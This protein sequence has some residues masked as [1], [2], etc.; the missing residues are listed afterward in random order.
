MIRTI[1]IL[2]TFILLVGILPAQEV[3]TGLQVN[4][5]VKGAIAAQGKPSLKNDV[6]LT[7][8]FF[9]D[10]SDGEVFPASARWTDHDVFINTD[11]PVFPITAG[12]ATFDAI[13]ANGELHS[14]ASDNRFRSDYLTSHPVRLDSVFLPEPKALDASDS[15]YLS[16]Y[17]Q[18]EGLG[19]APAEGDSL[20]LEF[21]HDH[22]VDSL[23]QWVKVWSTPGM[24]LNA[25]F[26]LH[27]SYFKNVMIPIVD[28]AYLK[29]GFR[30]R[31]YNIA[32]IRYPTAPSWQSNRDHWHVDYIYINAG[33]SIDDVFYP[34][35]ALVNNPGSLLKNYQ[36][37]P[38][39]QYKQNFVNEMRDSLRVR[40]SNLN[41]AATTGSYSYTVTRS[42]GSHLQTYESGNFTFQPFANAGYVSQPAI[43]RPPVSFVFPVN[44]DQ[45]AIFKITHILKSQDNYI[46]G[47][48]DTLH[49]TQSFRDYY[50]YDDGTAEAGYG[51]SSAGGMMAYKFRLNSPDT[52]TSVSIFFNQ[53][54]ND[55]NQRYFHFQVWNDIG[56]K[57]GDLIYEQLFDRVEYGEGLNGFRAYNFN[58]H[59]FIDNAGF[60]GLVFYVGLEQTTA[61]LLNIGLDRNNIANEQ[62]FY[63][64]GDTWFNSMFD[65]A[66]MIRPVLG[67]TGVSGIG[68]GFAA[69]IPLLVFPNP[70][71]DGFIN[72]KIDEQLIG[73][74]IFQI[75]NL[76]GVLMQEGTISKRMDIS[77]L[78]SGMYLLRL[79]SGQQTG[80]T[81]FTVLR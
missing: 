49:F 79:I 14:N 51:L 28:T 52:L 50:A 20:V 80:V 24:T 31:F 55:A 75:L 5:T 73:S 72:I 62:M 70:A 61:D 57:P 30:F 43:A 54:L 10:F 22:A 16:F 36:A 74:G 40:V 3:L 47:P 71:C 21:F 1:T 11:Y 33:R 58:E 27:G 26:A 25:F 9:D 38:Y 4:T 76:T 2:I 41:N 63:F 69:S 66:L 67:T 64:L 37:M 53:T 8:P 46:P 12:V 45:E 17:Y 29:P 6:L 48:N 23:K 7:L 81:R 13:D 56:G 19:F 59:I 60:P 78:P 39:R 42:D 65:G 34:D 44:N 32:S 68:P 77:Y 18:P 35:I 15:I